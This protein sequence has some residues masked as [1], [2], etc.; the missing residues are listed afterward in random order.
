[1]RGSLINKKETLE[2][3]S[4][5]PDRKRGTADRFFY[6]LRIMGINRGIRNK[7]ILNKFKEWYKI[8]PENGCWEWVGSLNDKG[9][10]HFYYAGKTYGAH[11]MSYMLFIGYLE[12]DLM[13][14]PK[15]V[16][17]FHLFKGTGSDNIVDAVNKGRWQKRRVVLENPS[18]THYNQGC[19]CDGCRAQYR[20]YDRKRDRSNRKKR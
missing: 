19:R 13:A 5:V 14:C 12:P 9:Y 8:N 11:R 2:P 17:P 6:Y 1:L 3:I 20:E 7:P 16:N 10:G 15:C 18:I 4:L